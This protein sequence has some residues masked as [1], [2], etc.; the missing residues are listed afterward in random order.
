M[1]RLAPLAVDGLITLDDESLKV[2]DLGRFFL[3]NVAMC[4]DAY[5]D[6]DGE[7]P[8]FSRTV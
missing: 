3:R 8:Q 7:K 4:F 1:D 6:T 5:L 2:T